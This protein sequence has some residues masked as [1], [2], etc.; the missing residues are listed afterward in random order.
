MSRKAEIIKMNKK[1]WITFYVPVHHFLIT[2]PPPPH[3]FFFFGGGGGGR[4]GNAV[5]GIVWY[6][7]LSIWNQVTLAFFAT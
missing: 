5:W 1:K 4:Q 2:T 6:R 3:I 7:Y